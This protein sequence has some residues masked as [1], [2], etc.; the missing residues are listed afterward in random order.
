MP[1]TKKTTKKDEGEEKKPAKTAAPKAAKPAKTAAPKAEKKPSASGEYN[2]AVGRRK[3][4]VATVKL[5]VKGDGTILVNGFAHN[6]YFKVFELQ[7]AL[8]APLKAVGLDEASVV[9]RTSG[10]GP[11]GQAEAARLGISRALLKVNEE[12][13]KTLKKMG[14]L[15]RDPREKERKKPGLRR[16]RKAAQW[17]KR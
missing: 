5:W 2:G 3:S 9:I 12:F 14:F 17:S 15:T 6:K 8:K 4:A 16:A 13:R 10:G 11:R 1:T 7:E